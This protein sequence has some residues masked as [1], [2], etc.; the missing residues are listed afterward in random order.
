MKKLVFILL[1]ILAVACNDNAAPKPEKLLD[2]GEMVDI[3]YDIAL[4]QAVKS[5]QPA[6]LD[7]SHVNT[8]TY[9]YKKYNIDSLT[10][11]QNNL[12]YASD[13]E[14][15]EKMQAKVSERIKENKEKL[16]PPVKDSLAKKTKSVIPK[17]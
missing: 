3:L 1:A 4:I 5:F 14:E 17:S 10:F 6:A 11:A 7:S 8:H 15:Y 13:I 9:I 2:S 12:Y 16:A